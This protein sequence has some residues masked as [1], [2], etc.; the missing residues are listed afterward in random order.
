MKR[1]IYIIIGI[2]IVAVIAVLILLFIKNR[3]A[4]TSTTGTLPNG[5]TTGSLP[6]TGTQGTGAS[7]STTTQSGAGT[8]GTTG[9]GGT[10]TSG[11]ST[12]GTNG[13]TVVQN[14]GVLSNDPILDYFVSPQNTITAIEPT[15]SIVTIAGG[16]STTINSSS[17]ND[18]ISAKFSYD[19][20]EIVVSFGN[21]SAPQTS[22]FNITTQ[23]WTALPQGLQSPVWAPTTDQIAYFSTTSNGEL[24]L[25]TINAANLKKGASTLLTLHAADL[26]LQWPSQNEL[27]IADKPTSQ[28]AGSIWAFNIP[29]ATLTALD[30]EIPGAE[31]IWSNDPTT[32]YGLVFYNGAGG[33]SNLLQLQSLSG[34]ATTQQL[35]FI[36]L[37]SKCVFNNEMTPT[38]TTETTS[39][40]YLA[41]YCGIPRSSSGFSSAQLP[42]DY[43]TMALFTSDDIY[44]I[45]TATGDTQVL[46]NDQTQNMDV[47]DMKFFGNALFFV[48][49]YDQKLYGLT[50]A[51]N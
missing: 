13:Q 9:V 47:S 42:D 15:G 49:R 5:T 16:Q 46:W 36:T 39:S 51:A 12:T 19:G 25:S 45:N 6:V 40:A 31:S 35:S 4:A 2:I 44:K 43:E 48:N 17:I 29:A 32:S 41:L 28:N 14:F 11:S 30:Y 23:T 3:S 24:A 38:S 33:E 22:I 18:I 34:T 37:P 7:N 1:Y 27:I 26:D 20:K 8:T 10:G 50:F 21:P